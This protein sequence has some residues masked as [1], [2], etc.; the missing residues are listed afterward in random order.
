[1][2]KSKQDTMIRDLTTGSVSRQLISFSA[3]LFFSGLLQ[4]VYS[5]VDMIVVGQFV[6]S[7][8]LSAVSVGSEILNV[9][10]F[11][12]MGVSNAGQIIIS[13]FVGANR[14]DDVRRLIGTMFSF[15]LLCAAA[16]TVICLAIRSQ[17]L[18]WVNVPPEALEQAGAYVSTCICGLIFVYGYNLVS[19][20]LRGM[21]D[22]RHPFI[23]VAIAS[24]INL[25]LDL[26]FIAGFHWGAFGAALATIIGQAVSFIWAILFLYRSRE[27][28]GFD[29]RPASFRIDRNMLRPLIRL[30]I[31]MVLQSAA[32]SI[33]HLFITSQ[34][35]T[36]GVVASAVT[37]V[38]AKLSSV[39]NVF[40]SALSTAGGSMIAQNIGAR[41]YDRIPR[42]I[43]TSFAV[44]G[45]VSVALSLV[46]IL[47]PRAVFG[48]FTS[49]EAVLLMALE[50]I[51][52]AVLQYASCV[53]RQPM[54]SLIN[55]T[56]NSNLNLAVALLDGIVVRIGLAVVLG[57]VCGFGVYGFWYGSALSSFV[58]FFIGGVYY[59][60]GRWR[61][62]EYILNR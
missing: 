9:L 11:V 25:V 52:V 54:S 6:G 57:R 50:Y 33:S 58:P 37:G 4:T 56:G 31:P 22:S 14:R 17:M 48:L 19:A 23:F 24:V 59:L 47:F 35:N 27:S 39:T 16:L 51:P 30:G 21:G 28:F 60:S 38:G 49:D 43:V 10:M 7:V 61:T 15:L 32:I 20:I 42:I 12:A 13:Q 34:V 3:P 40:A 44:D 36:Y 2:Q 46:T 1:M 53:L 8:G 29:F 5:M 26:V 55:G 18:S 62:R 45:V 41:K